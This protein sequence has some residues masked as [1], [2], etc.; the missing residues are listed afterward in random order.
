MNGISYAKG[1]E[2]V[3]R[4]V[5][6]TLL[7]AALMAFS[8]VGTA[9]A[10]PAVTPAPSAA[11]VE[12]GT[13]RVLLT[14]PGTGLTALDIE[15]CGSYSIDGN[16]GF[17]FE[18]GARLHLFV[19]EGEPVLTY[20]GM[21]MH[22][23]SGFSLTRHSAPGENGL[24]IGDVRGLYEGDLSVTVVDGA[25]R[26]VLSIYIED[27]L[28]GVVPYEMSD[29]FPI[30]ALK[31]QAVAA[32]TY[33]L[34][35]RNVS[36]DYDIYDNTNDQVFRGYEAQYTNAV[37]AVEQT[38]GLVGTYDGK[39]SECFY[40][41]S[42][43]GQTD[44]YVN[45]FGEEGNYGYLDMRDDPYDLGNTQSRIKTASVPRQ[46]GTDAAIPEALDALLKSAL[47]E[48]L[49][50]M[51]YDDSAEN[52]AIIDISSIKPHTPKCSVPSRVFTKLRFKL[53][54]MARPVLDEAAQDGT[55]DAAQGG[56]AVQGNADS[57]N[58]AAQGNGTNDTVQDSGIVIGGTSDSPA[59]AV[60][61]LALGD[62]RVLD[63][64]FTVDLDIFDA[65]EDALGLSINKSDNELI[66]VR[67]ENGKF[68][69]ESRRFG[70][71]LGMSQRGAERM[72]GQYGW[73]YEQILAFYYPG[74]EFV[75]RQY[76]PS[77][78]PEIKAEAAATPRP[79][80]QPTPRPTYIP[81][82]ELPEGAFYAEVA[83]AN[84]GSTL[85]L[86]AEPNTTAQV[87]YPLMNGQPLI[88]LRELGDGW[89]Q[90]QVGSYTGYVA[91][92]YLR[93]I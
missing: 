76:A 80:A 57:A 62:M 43:G 64:E 55:G 54:L 35:R 44:L 77:V 70:H 11:P 88:V 8:G 2:K 17:R 60:P 92:Q 83:L 86:R 46:P 67:E 25:L 28:K 1:G 7:M 52:I 33:A 34:R 15:L 23:G 90:V 41:A 78:L 36:R 61:E 5:I 82:G 84:D 59:D 45:A 18:R 93:L 24:R 87:L 38:R 21:T 48:Q 27:Y 6:L 19:S 49:A 68:I 4:N 20:E 50:S 56:D 58:D 3:T 37:L 40:S 66:S 22:M 71:G 74:M 53:R 29:S 32:R 10:E 12:D 30:E 26:L 89:V 13:V 65:V 72:A 47:S 51:G 39:L 14:Y 75:T 81:V 91:A 42:N 9:L 85:N 73:T 31:A 63:R 79:T 69:I 16:P